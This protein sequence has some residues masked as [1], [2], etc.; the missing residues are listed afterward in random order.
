MSTLHNSITKYVGVY[1]QGSDCDSGISNCILAI[2]WQGGNS[3]DTAFQIRDK[4][5]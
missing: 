5:K 2:P 4:F 3:T 1:A